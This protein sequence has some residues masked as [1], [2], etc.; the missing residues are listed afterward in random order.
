[1][2]P[3]YKIRVHV[4]DVDIA[5]GERDDCANWP[6][7]RAIRRALVLNNIPKYA[8]GRH[9]YVG[10]EWIDV[11]GYKIIATPRV[12]REF[13]QAYDDRQPVSPFDFEIT[14]ARNKARR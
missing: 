1:M 7:A 3:E 4:T 11:H 6:A 9:V 13:I 5:D 12:V 10:R 14:L 8:L 2:I